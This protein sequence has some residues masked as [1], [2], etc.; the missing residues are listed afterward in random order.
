MGFLIPQESIN[1]NNTIS[2]IF[3][4]IRQLFKLF[5]LIN[6]KIIIVFYCFGTEFVEFTVREIKD[7][8]SEILNANTTGILES[9][10]I[11]AK[12]DT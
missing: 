5:L 6:R 10:K 7:W 11:D 3:G 4:Y 8:D 1:W 2:Y 9:W 12:Y